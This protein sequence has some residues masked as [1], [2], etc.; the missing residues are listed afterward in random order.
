MNVH[1]LVKELENCHNKDME[2][3]F[4]VERTSLE[5]LIGEDADDKDSVSITIPKPEWC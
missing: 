2:V 3:G 4:Q 1:E 5:L